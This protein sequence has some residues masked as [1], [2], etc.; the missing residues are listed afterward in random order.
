ML[1]GK[2][3]LVFI[4][5][6]GQATYFSAICI[7]TIGLPRVQVQINKSPIGPDLINNTQLIVNGSEIDLS[8]IEE[9]GNTTQSI[10]G[11]NSEIQFKRTN[12]TLTVLFSSGLSLDVTPANVSLSF[13]SFNYSRCYTSKCKFVLVVYVFNINISI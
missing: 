8:V 12:S 5:E 7:A 9:D 10:D 6:L 1:F 11:I 2:T 3:L 13:L 4:I